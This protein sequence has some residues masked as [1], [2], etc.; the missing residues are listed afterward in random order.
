MKTCLIIILLLEIAITS[1]YAEEG[2]PFHRN[3]TTAEYGGHNRNFDVVA[4]EKGMMFFANF[5][6]LLCYDQARWRIIRTPGYSRI[7]CLMKDSRGTVWLAGYNFIARLTADDHRNIVMHPL[8]SDAEENGLGEIKTLTEQSGKITLRNHKGELFE[9]VEDSLRKLAGDS[10]TLFEEPAR[11]RIYLAGTGLV[12]INQTIRL[13]CGWNA[14]A[15][16]NHGLIILDR[17]GRKLYNLTEADGLCSNSLNRITESENGCVWGVTDNGIFCVYVPSMFSQYTSAQGLKGEVTTIQRYRQRLYIGTLQGLYAADQERIHRIPDINQ[18]CWKLQL[19]ADSTALY[20]ATSEGVFCLKDNRLRQLTTNYTQTL[21]CDGTDLY[22]AE[23]DCLRKLPLGKK[24]AQSM[25]VADIDKVMVLAHRKSGSI[26]AQDLDGNL[27]YKPKEKETFIPA[28]KL[29]AN[30]YNTPPGN[31]PAEASTYLYPLRNKTLRAIYSENDSTVVWAG[32]DFGMI[33]INFAAED[34]SYEHLPHVFIREVRLNGDS[35]HFGGV[36]TEQDWIDGKQNRNIPAFDCHTKE[37]TF[38]FSSDA[39]SAQGGI[40]YRFML[41][42]YDDN[43]SEWTD[44]TKKNYANLFYGSYIFKVQARDAFGRCTENKEYRFLIEWPFYLQWYSLLMYVVLTVS[45]VFL[46]IKWRLRKLIKEKERLEGIVVSRTLQIQEQKEEIEKK[47]ANLEEALSHLRRAQENLLR[48]EKMATIGKLTRGLIDRILNPLN[49]INNFS[50]LS[51]G[52]AEELRKNLCRIKDRIDAEEYEDSAD[53][54]DMLSSNLTKI[55][56][57][58][59]NT[60]RILKAM[61]EILKETNR[62]KTQVD[63]TALC[64]KSVELLRVYYHDEI[65]SMNVSV[66]TR[67]PQEPVTLSGNEEQLSKT[68]MSL[69]N[70]SM[71]AVSRKYSKQAYQP[72]ISLTLETD[73][74]EATVHLKDNGTGIEQTIM[75]QIFDPFFTTKTTGEAAGVGLYLS[76][77]II[78]SHQGEITVDSH[79]GEYTEF[80]IKLPLIKKQVTDL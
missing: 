73:G 79:K 20:A 56:Q 59:S 2:V 70:N 8:V 47:S 31:V 19:S 7:T 35:L 78:L 72:V 6:G 53:L 40:T 18:A 25:K 15:T 54:L 45:L 66:Q 32:G 24:N 64:R 46:A 37:V 21:L 23:M 42:G 44:A 27:Y 9:V 52:L 33:R 17:K 65:K 12:E 13:H 60:S 69:L 39:S 43:W 58:G 3:Y 51:G 29:P 14:L 36:F 48:Q 50:H 76:R 38:R 41:D 74:E 16:R 62:M 1:L 30:S 11:E 26:L 4:G 10:H 68:L 49:Y 55:E 63:M 71:Y 22:I 57:H 67:F 80:I 5:E 75:E 61:E 34:A 77:E 28:G